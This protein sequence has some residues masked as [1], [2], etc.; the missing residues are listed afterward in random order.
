MPSNRCQLSPVK[1]ALHRFEDNK[2]GPLFNIFIGGKVWP[3]V[4]GSLDQ[5]SATVLKVSEKILLFLPTKHLRIENLRIKNLRIKIL[6]I[7]NSRD[8]K[9]IVKKIYTRLALVIS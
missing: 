9:E 4:I 2:Y 1:Q 7:K 5:S 8:Q 6:R 3:A